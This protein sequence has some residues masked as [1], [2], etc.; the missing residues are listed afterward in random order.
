[1]GEL[2]VSLNMN[3]ETQD[4]IE[5]IDGIRSSEEPDDLKVLDL[6]VTKLF[7]SGHATAAIP[8]LFRLFE[9]FPDKDGFEVFWSVL[10]GLESL[11]GYETELLKSVQR[12]PSEFSVRM[13]NRILNTGQKHVCDTDLLNLLQQVVDNPTALHSVQT[14]AKRFI[15][16][17]RKKG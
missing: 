9:R 12:K 2:G 4:L 15:E 14:E 6:A 11:P 3:S 5:K 8:C 13:V 1:V 10:H 7:Q 17:Q 16:Y